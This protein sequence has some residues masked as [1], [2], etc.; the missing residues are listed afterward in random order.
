MMPHRAPCQQR[1]C[2]T[3]FGSIVRRRSSALPL[4]F[5]GWP[6][7]TEPRPF[8]SAEIDE[9]LRL[10]RVGRLYDQIAATFG[11]GFGSRTIGGISGVIGSAIAA[12]AVVPRKEF[13]TR[14]EGQAR[15]A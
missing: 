10:Y 7:R 5:C 2:E 14:R 12:G 4:R 13:F 11:S 6:C 1:Y 9:V 3:C 8:T 15:A